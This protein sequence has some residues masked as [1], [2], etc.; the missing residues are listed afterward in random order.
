MPRHR[1]SVKLPPQADLSEDVLIGCEEGNDGMESRMGT[2]IKEGMNGLSGPR[3]NITSNAV[4]KDHV[5]YPSCPMILSFVIWIM[6]FV[7]M[8][9]AWW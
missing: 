6:S 3:A 5:G 9:P 8:M 4:R 2:N 7:G 1:K